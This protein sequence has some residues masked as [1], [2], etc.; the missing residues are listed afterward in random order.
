[1]NWG[2]VNRQKP[3]ELRGGDAASGENWDSGGKPIDHDNEIRR[4]EAELLRTLSSETLQLEAICRD[5]RP[6]DSQ[7]A[8][9][10][11]QLAALNRV[12]EVILSKGLHTATPELLKAR[13]WS[14]LAES[15]A[16]LL[17]SGGSISSYAQRL[18][19]SIK[20]HDMGN[21]AEWN[22]PRQEFCFLKKYFILYQQLRPISGGNAFSAPVRF[23]NY[24]IWLEKKGR[25]MVS[26]R[27][28]RRD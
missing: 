2:K 4:L 28:G 5:R 8:R 26:P 6:S 7:A 19:H 15:Y 12:R 3:V 24:L 27:V 25:R 18:D 21:H 1:M 16:E 10:V 13:S 20:K 9:L 11:D 23:N 17:K 22:I 14:E